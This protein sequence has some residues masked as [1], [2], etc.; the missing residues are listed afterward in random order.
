MKIKIKKNLIAETFD[1]G[2]V[3]LNISTGEYLELDDT[4]EIFF[5]YLRELND[6][7]KV[8]AALVAHFDINETELSKDL[9]HFILELNKNSLLEQEEK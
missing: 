5:N 1:E 8:L 2:M 7:E 6:Y 3:I 9:D 4:G